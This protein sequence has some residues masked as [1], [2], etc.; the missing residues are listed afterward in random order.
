MAAQREAHSY[1]CERRSPQR[2]L[3]IPSIYEPSGCTKAKYIVTADYFELWTVHALSCMQ[4][5]GS[6]LKLAISL[7]RELV[8]WFSWLA[9]SPDTH[10]QLLIVWSPRSLSNIFELVE[11]VSKTLCVQVEIYSFNICFLKKNQNKTK[12]TEFLKFS[13]KNFQ[14][15]F[16]L[17]RNSLTS[18]TQGITLHW[19]KNAF[20]KGNHSQAP[21]VI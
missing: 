3:F 8:N 7:F 12:K 2:L 17:L 10:W 5:M 1:S 14:S 15:S 21:S 19:E 20:R 11:Y 4:C 9:H 16:I 6:H 13:I 18:T